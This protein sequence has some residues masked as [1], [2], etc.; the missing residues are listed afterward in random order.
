[1]PATLP[2][3]YGPSGAE[4]PRTAAGTTLTVAFRHAAAELDGV[5]LLF[6]Q[7]PGQG[8]PP[9]QEAMVEAVQ[10]LPGVSARWSPQRHLLEW[11]AGGSYRSLSGPGFGLSTPAQ[12]ARSLRPVTVP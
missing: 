8:L 10:L 1:M 4:T 12:A 2:A 3:G 9:P 6:S 7:A 11:V 5:G